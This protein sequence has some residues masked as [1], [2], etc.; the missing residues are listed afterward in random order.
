ME[1]KQAAALAALLGGLFCLVI[2]AVIGRLT[3]NAIAAWVAVGVLCF[4]FA[5]AICW[6]HPGNFWF[7]GMLMNL[8]LWVL[9]LATIGA[10]VF[11]EHLSGLALPLCLAYIGAWMGWVLPRRA[12]RSRT[13]T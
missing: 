1:K 13:R 4:L 3:E 7:T 12:K 11:R 9:I 10:G 8:T 5:M 6:D 2:L